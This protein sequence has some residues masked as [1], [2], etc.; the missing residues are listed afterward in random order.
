LLTPLAVAVLIWTIGRSGG[1][2]GGR[3]LALLPLT[4]V[5][6][7]ELSVTGSDLFAIGVLFTTLT[8]LA[9]SH[10]P[11][12]PAA[13]AIVVA[14]LVGAAASARAPFAWVTANLSLFTWRARRASA[15][16]VA[17]A[18]A[19]TAAAEVWLWW[20][21]RDRT[22]FHLLPK[23]AGL[24]GTTGVVIAIGAAVV[25]AGLAFARVNDSLETG[26]LALWILLTG[27]LAVVSIG[28]LSAAGWQIAAWQAAGYIVVSVPALVA[29]VAV[30]TAHRE[31][32]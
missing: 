10:D 30:Y 25:S 19:A 31:M 26:W 29:Y 20:P 2:E 7:W 5:G 22:P 11:R 14:A 18:T 32:T 13:G 27:P 16:L 23:F 1:G 3:A 21:D 15:W 12:H 28:V 8:A 6:F 9:W 24:F 17:G 4:G